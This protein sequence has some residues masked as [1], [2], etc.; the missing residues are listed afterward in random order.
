V[1]FLDVLKYLNQN[2]KLFLWKIYNLLGVSN[3]REVGMT[4]DTQVDTSCSGL[5]TYIINTFTFL[6]GSYLHT[7]SSRV[8]MQSLFSESLQRFLSGLAC[9]ALSRSLNH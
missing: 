3:G 1:K 4:Q 6:L 2:D 7:R 9:R 5:I 8:W